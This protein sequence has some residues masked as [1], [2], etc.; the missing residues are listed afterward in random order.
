MNDYKNKYKDKVIGSESL[1]KTLDKLK[2]ENQRLINVIERNRETEILQKK[3]D[4]LSKECQELTK[5]LVGA[6][7]RENGYLRRCEEIREEYGCNDQELNEFRAKFAALQAKYNELEIN[8]NDK[9]KQSD[10]QGEA[11]IE[12]DRNRKQLHDLNLHLTS[13]LNHEKEE[14]K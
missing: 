7:E 13:Q 6:R 1:A 2:T 3:I 11:V 10:E 4:S 14:L 12:L 9:C 5:D 8:Y